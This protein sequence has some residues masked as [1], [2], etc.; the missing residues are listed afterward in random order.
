MKLLRRKALAWPPFSRVAAIRIES[1][2]AQLAADTA[3]RLGR[4]MAS[5]MTGASGVRLLGPAPAPIMKIKGKTSWQ[6]V[7]KGPTHAAMGPSLD[8][9]E[10]LMEELPQAVKVAIDVD[11]SALM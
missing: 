2:D 5:K 8:A 4:A 6:L 3:K 1:D 7:L 11:P 9:A 10:A